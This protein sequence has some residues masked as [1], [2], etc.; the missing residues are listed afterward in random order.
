MSDVKNTFKDKSGDSLKRLV[1]E[2]FDEEIANLPL[3]RMIES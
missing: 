3:G 1:Y 2:I